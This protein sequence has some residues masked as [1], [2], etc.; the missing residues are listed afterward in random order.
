[1]AHGI[2]LRATI[3]GIETEEQLEIVRELGCDEVQGY[4]LSPP[5]TPAAMPR[6][7]AEI[8]AGDWS[9]RVRSAP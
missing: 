3:E 5:V 2:G 9:K 6:V 1:M 8:D 7:V 4:L